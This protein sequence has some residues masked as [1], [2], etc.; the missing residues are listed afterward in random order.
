M[1]VVL[2]QD[3]KALGKKG[4]I[5]EVSEGYARNFLLTKKYAVEATPANLNTLKLQKANADRIAAEQLAEAKDIA[6]KLENVT[7]TVAIK[8]E[9][10]RKKNLLR[11]KVRAAK[12][13]QK[14]ER[15]HREIQPI[16]T[17]LQIPA[18]KRNS[19]TLRFS[20]GDSGER[21]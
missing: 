6:E 14:T 3:V 11:K 17:G 4:D 5:A 20:A 18:K 2:L 16:N 10:N 1:K 7:V 9:E 8:A 13:A 12:K 15:K 19:G 21:M